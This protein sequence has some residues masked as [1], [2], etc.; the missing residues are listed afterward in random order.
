MAPHETVVDAIARDLSR[1]ILGGELPA[2]SRLASVRALADEHGVN[3]STIQRVLVRL[4]ERGLV[5]TRPRSGVEVCDPHRQGGASLWPLL[6]DDA[7]RE[8]E[9]GARLL[10]D[11]LETR[12]VLALHVVRALAGAP[13]SAHRRE[14]E[15]RIAALA[16]LVERSP[17]DLPAMGRCEA[18]IVRSILIAADRPAV[19]AVYNDVQSMLLSCRPVLEALY[20]NPGATVEAWRAF[21]ALITE[22]SEGAS[23]DFLLPLLAAHDARVLAAFERA[24][25]AC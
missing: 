5:T 9:R 15:R 18:E 12:R 24:V 17:A 3:V 13:F 8:P 19:L 25:N 11:A 14:I 21:I 1:R 22:S 6:L 23:F 2:G 20:E 4:E 7:I 16:T 10:A